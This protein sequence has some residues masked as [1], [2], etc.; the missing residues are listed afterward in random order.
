[1]GRSRARAKVIGF[2]TDEEGRVRPIT[3]RSGRRRFR[4][5]LVPFLPSKLGGTKSRIKWMDE[6]ER[7]GR[8]GY[9]DFARTADKLK[10]HE[11]WLRQKEDLLGL[12]HPRPDVTPVEVKGVRQIFVGSGDDYYRLAA[13]MKVREAVSCFTRDELKKMGPLFVEVGGIDIPNT[14]GLCEYR[15]WGGKEVGHLIYISPKYV[16]CLHTLNHELV[17]ARRHGEG[18]WVKDCDREEKM[19]ELESIARTPFSKIRNVGYYWRIPEVEKLFREGPSRWDEG[20]AL[21]MELIKKDKLMM[22]GDLERVL[23]GKEA[24][25]VVESYYSRSEIA[26]ARF[27]PGEELDRYFEI[28]KGG[29]TIKLHVRFTEPTKLEEIK[30][31]LMKRYGKDIEAWEWRDGKKVKII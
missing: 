6:R 17:H 21:A 2:Y 30:K 3:A 4:V 27:S 15:T 11:P 18:E 29:E 22:C 24:K 10:E 7:L 13:A 14:A 5:K 1:M 12:D 20:K 16:D 19:T 23:K 8:S 28:K 9:V 25:R 26:R 31:G